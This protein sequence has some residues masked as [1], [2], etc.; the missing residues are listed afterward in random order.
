MA[1]SFVAMT[2]RPSAT[3]VDQN[4]A[5]GQDRAFGLKLFEASQEMALNERGVFWDF[6]GGLGARL[7]FGHIGYVLLRIRYD[8]QNR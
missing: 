1:F 5:G 3:A 8:K 7:C 6:P 2:A 4:E